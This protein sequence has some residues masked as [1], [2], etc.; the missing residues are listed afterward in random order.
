MALRSK[1]WQSCPCSSGPVA[2]RKEAPALHLDNTAE[3]GRMVQVSKSQPGGHE[4]RGNL[5]TS[6][7][8]RHGVNYP[9]QYWRAQPGDEDWEELVGWP[10]MKMLRL[11]TRI[12]NW[13]TPCHS[14]SQTQGNSKI[15]L[16]R[17]RK[18]PVSV[19]AETRRLESDSL[20]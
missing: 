9:R 5:T 12:K 4:N 8:L 19:R 13:Y 6:C 17:L 3:L 18:G 15:S 14:I 2:L 10:P 20:E 16:R 1:G 7:S 11:K